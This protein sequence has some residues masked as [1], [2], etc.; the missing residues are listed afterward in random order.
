MTNLKWELL[1][2]TD[3]VTTQWSGG[4]TTQL[5]IAP[6]GAVYTKYHQNDNQTHI[7]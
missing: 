5:A 7:D 3:Y 1:T 6:E 2:Q 4:T